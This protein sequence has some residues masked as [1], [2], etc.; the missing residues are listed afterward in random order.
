[1]KEISE[2]QYWQ[3]DYNNREHGLITNWLLPWESSVD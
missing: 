2:S 3:L 1:M